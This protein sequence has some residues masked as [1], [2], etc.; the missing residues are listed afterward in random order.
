MKM[1]DKV[2]EF[3]DKFFDLAEQY[4]TRDVLIALTT[5]IASIICSC[6]EKEE[7]FKSFIIA[8]QTWVNVIGGTEPLT[9]H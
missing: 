1:N 8:M 9:R 7:M 4:E 6:E 3:S 5:I 2:E